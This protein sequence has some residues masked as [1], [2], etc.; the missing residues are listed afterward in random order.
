MKRLIPYRMFCFAVAMTT[1]PVWA[2]P[3]GWRDVD[4][5]GWAAPFETIEE[6]FQQIFH[7]SADGDCL[8]QK[9]GNSAERKIDGRIFFNGNEVP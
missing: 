4:A 3:I 5:S 7:I 6:D 9:L 1:L 2:I 8:T